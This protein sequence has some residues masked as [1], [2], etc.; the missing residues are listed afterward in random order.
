MTAYWSFVVS[1]TLA[2][3]HLNFSVADWNVFQCFPEYLRGIFA[4]CYQENS[5]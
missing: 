2:Q 1:Y 5:D 3:N 4:A